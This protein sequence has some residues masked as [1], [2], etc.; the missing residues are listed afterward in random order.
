MRIRS[1]CPVL[2]AI[3]EYRQIVVHK[4]KQRRVTLAHALHLLFTFTYLTL[5]VFIPL[6]LCPFAQNRIHD[7]TRPDPIKVMLQLFPSY[8]SN[9]GEK[10][11]FPCDSWNVIEKTLSCDMREA[12]HLENL[13]KEKDFWFWFGLKPQ[14]PGFTAKSL[15]RTDITS[16]GYIQ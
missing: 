3:L 9:G 4:I 11:P 15:S 5:S 13:Y 10:E 14:E 6:H 1:Y 16:V 8:H 12:R 2:L 7:Q